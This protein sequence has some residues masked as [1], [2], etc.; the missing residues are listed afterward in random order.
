MQVG[1]VSVKCGP[2]PEAAASGWYVSL[3][4][5]TPESFVTP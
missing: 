5:S 2:P 4:K 1:F 3:K